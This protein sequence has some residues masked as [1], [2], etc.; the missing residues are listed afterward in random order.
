MEITADQE[1]RIRQATEDFHRAM[2]IRNAMS[3]RVAKRVTAIL[4][5]GMVSLGLVTIILM[6]M[7]YAFTSKMG[8]MIVALNTMNTEFSS[9]A[10]DMTAMKTTL[11]DMEHIVAHV[12]AIT[13]ATADMT[14]TVGNMRGSVEAM[15]QTIGQLNNEVHTTAG[16]VA[17]MTR[18]IRTLDPAVQH[19]GRDVNRMSGPMRMINNINPFD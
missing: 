7:L 10:Q 19:M 3:V 13:R 15:Q 4:R 6:M 8:E 5:I 9:M 14:G 1:A 11:Y 12:P 17:S 2:E 18:Q 16:Q